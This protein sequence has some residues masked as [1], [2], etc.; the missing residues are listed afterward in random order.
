MQT[1]Q[2]DKETRTQSVPGMKSLFTL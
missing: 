1:E 2:Q